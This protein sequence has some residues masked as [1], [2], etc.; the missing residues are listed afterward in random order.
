MWDGINYETES[1]ARESQEKY[2]N[3]GF[4]T[5]LIVEEEKFYVFSRRV[6]KEIQIDGA[7]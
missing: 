4:E 2:A 1:A 5:T 6:A 7:H 3:D